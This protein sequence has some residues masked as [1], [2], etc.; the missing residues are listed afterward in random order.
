MKKLMYLFT[1]ILIALC[2]T[3]CHGKESM[4]SFVVPT[5]FDTSRDYEITFWAKNDSNL[6]QKNIYQQAIDNFQKIYPNIHVTMVS[7]TDYNQIYNDVIT[8]MATNTTPN[9]CIS[10]PDNVATYIEGNNVV[11]PLDSLMADLRYGLGGTQILFD[12]PTSNEIV[13]SFLNECIINGEYYCIPYM[14]SS[15]ALYINEDLV[16][17]LGYSIPDKITWDYVFEVS[18]AAM[19]MGTYE[20]GGKKY[21]SLND[22]TVLIPFIYKSTDNMVIQ[23]LK[24]KGA[25]YSTK[26][27][28]ILLFND[29]LSEFIIEVCEHVKNGAFDTFSNVSYPGNYLN[30]GACIF[31]V[32]STAGATWMGGNAPSQDIHKSQLVD[33]NLVVKEIP[34]VDVNNP[35]MISQGPSLCLFNKEDPQE[36]LASWIFTQ[37]LLTNETQI[38][39]SQTEGYVPVTLKA[40]NSKDYLDYLSREG[41]NNELYYAGKIQA[42]KLVLRNLDNTF[43][44]PVFNGS[45]SLRNAAGDVL[46]YGVRS[47]KRKKTVDKEYLETKVYP[48]TI[49]LRRLNQISSVFSKV[50]TKLEF[51]SSLEYYER[52]GEEYY[53]TTDTSFLDGKNYYILSQRAYEV[54]GDS[55]EFDSS[56]KYYVLED[57]KFHR[58]DISS[59]ENGVTYYT[60]TNSV[61]GNA[62]KN[63]ALG[64]LPVEA[65]VLLTS[66]GVAWVSISVYFILQEIKRR[67]E[68]KQ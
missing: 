36:V 52:I 68:M 48:E 26:Y 12:S 24:Q 61:S 45:V 38:A 62:Q 33:F 5:K 47:T 35:L 41:E 30:Q 19:A 18:D 32:D 25:D 4:G 23:Y 9:V 58:V 17:K 42:A 63:Q 34:Q 16:K 55:E 50:D 60:L 43:T 3:G 49:E 10:Y 8:N 6:T 56:K 31:A 15:E 39:Y 54:V 46:E 37:Y 14:R 51:D 1:L 59:F 65:I 27:G 7:Y 2:I 11:V 40:Q 20:E 67:K 57:E 44:T 21:Y 53:L 28:D 29:T 64:K 13:P 66:L 22:N